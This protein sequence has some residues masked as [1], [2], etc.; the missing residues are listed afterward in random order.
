MAILLCQY[1]RTVLTER[2]IWLGFNAIFG[3]FSYINIIETISIMY[4]HDSG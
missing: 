1:K 4:Q 2:Q 3:H